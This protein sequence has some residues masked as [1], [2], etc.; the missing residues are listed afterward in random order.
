[1]ADKGNNIQQLSRT[2]AEMSK[3]HV[4]VQTAWVT[5]KSV[6]WGKKTMVAVGIDDELEYYDVLLGIGAVYIKPKSDTSCLI[7][8]IENQDAATFLIEAEEVEEA[9]IKFGQCELKMDASGFLIKRGGV[10]MTDLFQQL[11]DLL[12]QFGLT[13]PAGPT[14]GLLPPTM[15]SVNQLETS[16]KQLLT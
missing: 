4:K 5:V 1:M 14:T 12:K 3:K 7:G 2:L 15:A 10:S 11:V 8:M 16:F 13:T 6:D 9:E